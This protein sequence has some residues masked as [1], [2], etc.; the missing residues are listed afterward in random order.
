M[1]EV[2]RMLEIGNSVAEFDDE[3]EKYFVETEAFRSLVHGRADVVA[4][5]KG[6]G[7]TALFRILQKKYRQLPEL[8]NVEV[9]TAFNPTGNPVFQRLVQ[10]QPLTEGQYRSVWKT[11]FLSLV[12]NWS[13]RIA[14]GSSPS[15]SQLGELLERAGLDFNDDNPATVF[16]RLVNL[17]KKVIPAAAEAKFT[18]SETGIP[19]VVP[20]LEFGVREQAA[21]EE[22]SHEDALRLLDTCIGELGLQVWLVL[23]RLDEAFQGFP[24]VEVPALRALL[25]SYLDLGAYR[26]L[27][28]KLFVRRDLF[29]KII[30]AGFVNLTHINARKIEIVWDEDDLLSLLCRRIR[31][32]G[33]FVNRLGA[34]D[35][36]NAQLFAAVFPEQ[37]DAGKRK[38]TT[39]NWVMARI[40]DG[41]QVKPPRNLIDLSMKAREAQLRRE[42]R[43]ARVFARGVPIIESDAMRR[44]L[45]R[46]SEERVE[47]TLMAEAGD[48][49]GL[50]ER[51]RKQRSEHSRESLEQVLERRNG[52]L[53]VAIRRLQE[54]GF[55]EET[56]Q[57]YKIPMLYRD[58][59]QIVQGKAFD[60]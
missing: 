35:F 43:D 6:T 22:V 26:N 51:F 1:S 34:A 4:G 44:A 33:D 23:D 29:R 3:L 46:L 5:D 53:D 48:A 47:D 20:R 13:L 8:E 45:S 10:E 12:G 42:E 24:A 9:I 36:N 18:L 2:L 25:R 28:L 27:R 15:F 19:I 49:A 31:E 41:N 58:G 52:E 7:K 56:G 32:S 60:E 21:N 40:R 37:V 59:L 11:Y 16:N 17:V 39:W 38:P 50:V 54:I 30:G 57:T 14:A 55:L